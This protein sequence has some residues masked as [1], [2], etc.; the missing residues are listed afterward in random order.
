MTNLN[1]IDPILKAAKNPTPICQRFNVDW[2][3]AHQEGYL[4]TSFMVQ[5]RQTIISQTDSTCH[6]SRCAMKVIHATP[7][8]DFY[9]LYKDWPG[10][11]T[12]KLHR[13]AWEW[14]CCWACLSDPT[15]PVIFSR[16]SLLEQTFC[17]W[18][19]WRYHQMASAFRVL[20]FCRGQL[21]LSC[22]KPPVL[23][24]PHMWQAENTP[25]KALL[26]IP[27]PQNNPRTR[28]Q[29]STDDC[30]TEDS[31]AHWYLYLSVLIWGTCIPLNVN[32]STI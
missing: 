22:T 16:A 20:G 23:L 31:C 3:T 1:V 9:C 30:F 26:C 8:P 11:S 28:L 13:C 7:E 4:C 2:L 19:A 27:G 15:T 21:Q 5:Q 6:G 24:N 17:S 14:S 29:T 32:G 10:P 12:A 25:C 18:N